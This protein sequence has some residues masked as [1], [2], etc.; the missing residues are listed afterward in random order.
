M[1][2]RT[3]LVI[4]SEFPLFKFLVT[5]LLLPAML[6]ATPTRPATLHGP[7]QA[8]VAYEPDSALAQIRY[9]NNLY[10]GRCYNDRRQLSNF[11]VSSSASSNCN[12]ASFSLKI[13]NTFVS[14]NNGNVYSQAIAD[15]S[16]TRTQYF[17]YDNA[18]RLTSFTEG[19][20]VQTYNYDTWG[21]RWVDP[22]TIPLHL[23]TPTA[24]SNYS[25][26]TNRLTTATYDNTGNI[27]NHSVLGVFTWD[28]ESRLA[29]AAPP[30]GP[31][32]TFT[33]DG[34]SRRVKKG[35]IIYV[36][37][38]F[39]RLAQEV[40]GPPPPTNITYLSPDHLGSTRLVTG[41]DAAPLRRLDYFPFGEQMG[42]GINGRP[43][44][45]GSTAFGY[46][47]VV[48]HKFTSKER[49][50][51]TGLDYFGARY[52]SGAQGRFTSPDSPFADQDEYDPQSWNLYSY[53]R[54]NPLRF[55]DP[56]GR[57][58]QKMSNG[59]VYDDLDEKGCAAVDEA[60]KN[61]KPD[62]TV[63]VGWNE[64]RLFMLAG[65]GENL[66]SPHQWGTV[67]SGGAQGAASLLSP[68]PTAVAQC[69][70]G[71]CSQ[72]G[73]AMAM[74]PGGGNIKL[75]GKLLKIDPSK[76][77]RAYLAGARLAKG[78][79]FPEHLLDM[80]AKELKEALAKGLVTP[81]QVKRI[82]K[83]V[84]QGQRLMEKLGGR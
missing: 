13:T 35:S 21:N 39:G 3:R 54:N 1:V 33:Y 55:V 45:Y 14:P 17:G 34:H 19:G 82:A 50:P 26:T 69:L 23:A 76:P 38:A 18:N 5:A 2:N 6:L 57:T 78:E 9:G 4:Q 31:A 56:S 7:A 81:D 37:D 75:G 70:T 79:G 62:I 25:S 72:T 84:E 22:S 58:C 12:P 16:T 8:S 64:V 24:Q 53:V 51:E 29:T 36:Y 52:F 28:A 68:L 41:G 73:L 80:T 49:D 83:V 71:N 40:N 77:L 61:K 67:V 20:V 42:Q 46:T 43:N 44:I 11:Y 66:S 74:I 60:N 65:V 47:D 59:T 32:T 15:G 30:S 63:G 48:A 10:E 27:I